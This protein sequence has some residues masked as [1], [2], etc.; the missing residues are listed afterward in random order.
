MSLSVKSQFEPHIIL[1]PPRRIHRPLEFRDGL[2]GTIIH[3]KYSRYA[4]LSTLRMQ[5][6]QA[7][8]V[9]TSKINVNFTLA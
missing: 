4:N 5:L 2:I 7:N 1:V 9:L 8:I 3:V 6:T